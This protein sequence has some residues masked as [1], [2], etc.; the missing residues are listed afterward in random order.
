VNA[1]REAVNSILT[2][3]PGEP[4]RSLPFHQIPSRSRTVTESDRD[5]LFAEFTPLVR[6]LLRQYGDNAELR[7]DLMGEIYCQFQSLL[8]AYDPSRGIPL[9]PYLVRQLTA[10][11]YTYARRQ[12]RYAKHTISLDGFENLPSDPTSDW[13]SA[14]I[15][16]AVREA[17]PSLIAS[18]PARQR[19]VLIWRYYDERSFED[20]ARLLGVQEATARSLLRHSLNNLRKRMKSSQYHD[21]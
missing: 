1:R 15:H 12:W 5:A 21:E 19:C 3:H 6:R 18:L 7:K 16:Q 11:V 9:R 17:L 4:G 20:I 14:L 2:P 8:N 13:N 10:S